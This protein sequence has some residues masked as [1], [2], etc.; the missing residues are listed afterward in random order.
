MRFIFFN[1]STPIHPKPDF[2]GFQ[3]RHITQQSSGR[4]ELFL[5]FHEKTSENLRLMVFS[6]CLDSIIVDAGN[7]D[8]TR[9]VQRP[10]NV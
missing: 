6:L 5:K 10:Y 8:L 7:S 3:R 9:K 2:S 4:Y 1:F